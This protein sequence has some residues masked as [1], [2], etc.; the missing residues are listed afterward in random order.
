MTFQSYN[1][2]DYLNRR[3]GGCSTINFC[4][5]GKCSNCGSCCTNF[6]PVTDAEIRRIKRFIAANHIEPCRHGFSAPLTEKPVDMICP[7]RD[8]E[9]KICTIYKV[10]PLI[11]WGYQ[12][13][14]TVRKFA[15]DMYGKNYDPRKMHFINIR[16]TFYGADDMA[17]QVNM[18][19]VMAM[20]QKEAFG[21]N[22]DEWI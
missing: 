9:K 7:F 21:I 4:V 2:K 19:R 5:N 12:C 3:I 11:C 16:L 20:K 10:R 17:N 13:N 18:T 1:V 14:K 15:A 6:L 8:E 22:A